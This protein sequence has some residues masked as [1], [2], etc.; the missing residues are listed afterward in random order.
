MIPFGNRET[1]TVPT[2]SNLRHHPAVMA[3]RFA[4]SPE[5]SVICDG[6]PG[7]YFLHQVQKNVMKH[8]SLGFEALKKCQ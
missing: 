3:S 6:K 1:G 7:P 8:E 4:R 5:T 2:C